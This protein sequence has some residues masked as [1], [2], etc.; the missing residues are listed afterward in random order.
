[1]ASILD[2][3]HELIDRIVSEFQHDL[4]NLRT[5]ALISSVF[6]P[7]SRQRLFSNVRL[8]ASNIYAFRALI[9]SS[10][11]V[12]SYV[13]RLDMPM[14]DNFPPS[15][16][17]PPTTLAQLP[18]VTNLSAHSDPFDFRQLPAGQEIV[19]A[20]AV[21]RLTTVEVLIDRLWPLPAWAT[22][23]NGCPALATL[24]IK[25]EA[26]GWGTWSA[27]D[28]AFPMPASSAPGTL[29][30]RTLRVSGDCKILVPL[31]AWLV[32]QGALATLQ[33]LVVDVS[34]LLDDYSAPDARPALVLAAAP[35]LRELTLH[36]DPPMPLTSPDTAPSIRLASFPPPPCAPPPRRPRRGHRRLPPRGSAPSFSCPPPSPHA[37]T[38]PSALEELSLDHSMIRRDLL[39]VPAATWRTIEDALLGGEGDAGEQYPHLRSVTYKGCQKFSLGSSDAFEHFS[40]TVRERLPRL[41]ERGML[42]VGR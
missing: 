12:A 21:R 13:R 16:I 32:P 7:W 29:R 6:V 4:V 5:S 19:L 42:V 3:P 27:A 31:S 37:H 34:Y 38:E 14:M 15:A 2:L 28:V 20:E 23:L 11:T 33:T 17:L 10:P 9:E 18:N 1:M 8:T 39:A 24:V 36:L 30:L 22:L 35:S 41:V 40:G 25:A 26:T